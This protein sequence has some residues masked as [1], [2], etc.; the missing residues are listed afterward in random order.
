MM[1]EGRHA[2]SRERLS[3]KRSSSA[4]TD[5][6]EAAAKSRIVS[7]EFI[8][9]QNTCRSKAAPEISPTATPPNTR[10]ARSN[11]FSLM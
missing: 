1:S 10:A 11:E 6:N 3:V 8:P 9:N 4:H 7:S 5:L 2:R